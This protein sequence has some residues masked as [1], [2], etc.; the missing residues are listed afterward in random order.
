MKFKKIII[1]LI[2]GIIECGYWLP[3]AALNIFMLIAFGYAN[4]KINRKEGLV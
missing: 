4:K 2:V 3:P 1:W